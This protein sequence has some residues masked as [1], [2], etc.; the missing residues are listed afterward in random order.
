MTVSQKIT[1]LENTD[2]NKLDSKNLHAIC[3][4]LRKFNINTKKNGDFSPL[5]SKLNNYVLHHSF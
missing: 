3:K 1:E 5:Y 4:M 2:F